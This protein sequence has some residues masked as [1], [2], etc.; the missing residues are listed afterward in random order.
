MR[1]LLLEDDV[2]YRE[3]MEEYLQ[4]LGY[5]VESFGD[6]REALDALF[7][8]HYHLL[9]LDVRVP[10]MSGYE[11][12]RTLRE[13]GNEIPIILVTSLTD[14]DNLSV[15]YELG[16]NDYIRKP[17]ATRELRYRIEQ[18]LKQFYFQSSQKEVSLPADHRYD[19]HR[20]ALLDPEG[21]E[22]PLSGRER[23]VLEYLV[24]HLGQFVP[25]EEL[26]QELWDGKS[27][28]EADIRMCIKGIRDK[29]D[30]SL[31]VNR[32]GRGYRIDPQ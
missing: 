2:A 23:D 1:L 3:S 16:C 4:G 22:I 24:T 10:G 12:L 8:R 9:L 20:Q 26:W 27:V 25:V 7:E 32:R 29:S 17:F 11:I 6:G 19:L 21:Q 13:E 31:I 15:G 30:A 14:I 28:T 18:L 5:E